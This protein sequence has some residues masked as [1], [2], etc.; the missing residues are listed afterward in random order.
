M[1]SLDTLY[2]QV[3]LHARHF[4]F[5]SVSIMKH[6]NLTVLLWRQPTDEACK[7]VEHGVHT[8]YQHEITVEHAFLRV[9]FW[10]SIVEG[11][12]SP[13]DYA[14]SINQT[15]GFAVMLLLCE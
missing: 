8:T 6:R 11:R 2:F 9:T 15:W 13:E 14:L 5:G 1:L 10:R 4:L 12:I 7:D 3:A